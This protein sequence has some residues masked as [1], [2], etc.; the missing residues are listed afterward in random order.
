MR[1]QEE[2]GLASGSKPRNGACIFNRSNVHILLYDRDSKSRHEVLHLLRRCT[3]RVTAVET[4]RAAL[5]VLTAGPPVDLMLAEVEFPKGKGLKM[6]RHVAKQ[7]SLKAIP[8]V[9]MSPRDEVSVVVKCLRLGAADFLVKPLRI[10]EL[11]NLWTHMWRRRRT[12]GAADQ[13]AAAPFNMNDSLYDP[14]AF[15]ASE[16]NTGSTDLFS[17]DTETDRRRSGGQSGFGAEGGSEMLQDNVPSHSPTLEL[18]LTPCIPSTNRRP[19]KLPVLPEPSVKSP[20]PKERDSSGQKPRGRG[21]AFLNY[22]MGQEGGKNNEDEDC[23]TSPGGSGASEEDSPVKELLKEVPAKAVVKVRVLTARPDGEA[24]LSKEPVPRERLGPL[25]SHPSGRSSSLPAPFL[26]GLSLQHSASGQMP[27]QKMHANSELNQGLEVTG[28]PGNSPLNTGSK[29]ETGARP[30][31]GLGSL[32]NPPAHE[33]AGRFPGSLITGMHLHERRHSPAAASAE[34]GHSSA[35]AWARAASGLPLGL[36]HHNH[37]SLPSMASGTILAMSDHHSDSLAQHHPYLGHASPFFSG[38]GMAGSAVLPPH[39]AAAAAAVA[40]ATPHLHAGVTSF[41]HPA[42]PPVS[43]DVALGVMPGGVPPALSAQALA[44]AAAFGYLSPL[45]AAAAAAAAAASSSA[46]APAGVSA[47]GLPPVAPPPPNQVVSPLPGSSHGTVPWPP[48][49]ATDRA[50][51]LSERREAALSK[52]RQKRK[53]RCFEKKIRYA[54]RK[55]LAEQRPRKRGQFV[56][57]NRSGAKGMEEDDYGEEE[58]EEESDDD[59]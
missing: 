22:L 26:N 41:M 48:L 27:S 16:S 30:G 47:P 33:A 13:Q 37:M 55:R 1:Q 4:P 24:A 51:E 11:L 36:S 44:A 54:S 46:S 56:K 14:F 20:P 53:E 15:D 31:P 21:S 3:Y 5:E 59:Q 29:R 34:I 45:A 49:P 10:N 6:L 32:N 23:S 19:G 17:D 43:Q 12:L 42:M 38:Y 18:T 28:G 39:F 7:D 8:I 40:A 52:F 25:P 9:M 50:A 58:S 57:Q 35:M 2:N